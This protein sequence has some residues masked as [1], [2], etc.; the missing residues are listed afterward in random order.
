[1]AEQHRVVLAVAGHVVAAGDVALRDVARAGGADGERAQDGGEP[2]RGTLG[3]ATASS[4][5]APGPG[6]AG[7]K[8]EVSGR[9]FPQRRGKVKRGVV[10]ASRGASTDQPVSGPPRPAGGRAGSGRRGA[11]ASTRSTR[12]WR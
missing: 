6:P 4:T 3:H 5:G 12:P 10:E 9:T 2:A 7:E 1:A 8:L 11:P